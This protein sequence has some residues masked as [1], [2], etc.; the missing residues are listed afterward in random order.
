MNLKCLFGHKW[1]GCKCDRCG[2]TRDIFDKACIKINSGTLNDRMVAAVNIKKMLYQVS[3]T[4]ER[5]TRLIAA[6]L[7]EMERPV[8]REF[9]YSYARNIDGLNFNGN[10]YIGEL[11]SQFYN[12]T[13]TALEDKEKI[14]SFEGRLVCYNEYDGRLRPVYFDCK[15]GF[16]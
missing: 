4:P 5:K 16:R 10:L 1:N 15:N 2:A 13:D 3:L 6:L 7:Q 8:Q 9:D 11:L 14:K 12:D